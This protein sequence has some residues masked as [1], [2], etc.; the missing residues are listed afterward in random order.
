MG[1]RRIPVY[2]KKGI[3]VGYAKV[4][5]ADYDLLVQFRWRLH[6][7]HPPHGV[8]Y[9]KASVFMHRLV[10]LVKGADHV[11]GDGLNNLR[12]NLRRATAAQ[13]A[14]NRGKCRPNR[15]STTAVRST[16]PGVFWSQK[17]KR[18]RTQVRLGGKVVFGRTFLNHE[19]AIAAVRA[20]RAKYFTHLRGVA[21]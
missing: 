10:A 2:G 14:Q 20:A 3:I 5:E 17:Y 8:Q 19:E 6:Q 9:A 15:G 16:E 7:A 18:W 21:S 1:E 11:D 4:D 12:S 13:N